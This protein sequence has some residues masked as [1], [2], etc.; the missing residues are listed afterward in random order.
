MVAVGATGSTSVRL[1]LRSALA[2]AHRLELWER[3]RS[4]PV[5]AVEFRTGL[6]PLADNTAS[7]EYPTDFP[8]VAPLEPA[9]AYGFRITRHPGDHLVGEGRFETA[10]AKDDDVAARFAFGVMSCHQPF[11]AQGRPRPGALDLMRSL[12]ESFDL[13]QVKRVLMVG[14][15]MYSDYPPALSLFE[16]DYF[17][18]VR[19]EGRDT[20]LDCSVDEIRALYQLRYRVFWNHDPVLALHARF[21]AYTILDDHEVVD[22]FG[23]S[24]EH[25]GERW[26]NLRQGA[27]AAFDDYQGSRV[28]PRHPAPASRH[29]AFEYGPVATFVMDLRSE[30]RWVGEQLQI[31][32]AAQLASLS[33]FLLRHSHKRAVVVV[34]SVPL[35]HV[36][37]WV[38]NA[39]AQVAGTSSDLADRWSFK[40][41]QGSRD[42]L[43]EL[44]REHHRRFPRQK[45]LLLGGDIHSGVVSRIRWDHHEDGIVQFVSSAV[46]N[47]QPTLQRWMAEALPRVSADWRLSS[48]ASGPTISLLP[49]LGANPYGGLN[50]G[51]LEFERAGG[52][53]GVRMKLVTC[54]EPSSVARVAF[55]SELV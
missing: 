22:N 34:V 17:A 39:G 13:H 14:D 41:A 40:P 48:P 23:S 53:L 18:R 37:E 51:I 46:S 3:A 27:L 47:L 7:L 38:A 20:I 32:S 29:H 9:T 36:P 16:P 21:P 35:V 25:G 50:A 8:G 6:D 43:C 44:L 31:Y 12:P 52:E 5:S 4:S 11:D 45:L 2:G 24:P 15:Q 1:W 54:G 33:E 28:R 30:R 10:P 55:E 26:H 49:G 19:P 42:Q